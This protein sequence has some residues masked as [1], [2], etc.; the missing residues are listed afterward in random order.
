M[1]EV[2]VKIAFRNHPVT[3][4]TGSTFVMSDEDCEQCGRCR[5]EEG[6]YCC[7]ETHHSAYCPDCGEGI[8]HPY[9]FVCEGESCGSCGNEIEPHAEIVYSGTVTAT[10]KD[11]RLVTYKGS[12]HPH[13][14]SYNYCLGEAAELFTDVTDTARALEAVITHVSNVDFSDG[15]GGASDYYGIEVA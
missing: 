4:H 8:E 5:C 6:G 15:L 1:T 10:W 2:S 3:N 7:G 9:C 14:Q 12:G 11:G 13:V